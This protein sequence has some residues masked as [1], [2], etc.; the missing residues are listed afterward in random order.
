MKTKILFFTLMLL[1]ATSKAA[2]KSYSK[3]EQELSQWMSNVKKDSQASKND[4][5]K[6]LD[7]S[8]CDY[9][10]KCNFCG[11]FP[12]PKTWMSICNANGQEIL[13]GL[14]QY[15]EDRHELS[16]TGIW[17]KLT[18]DSIVHLYGSFSISNYGN[19]EMTFKTKKGGAL[20]VK[21]ISICY[22][23]GFYKDKSTKTI[24]K[25]AEPSFIAIERT[26][27]TPSHKFRYLYA[28]ISSSIFETIQYDDIPS[29]LLNADYDVFLIRND[30][31][32]EGK[33][34][35][36]KINDH[37]TVSYNF[38]EGKMI[39]NNSP[40][41]Y[42]EMQVDGDYVRYT[43]GNCSTN[44]LKKQ[45]LF[46]PKEEGKSIAE[47][48]DEIYCWE[49]YDHIHFEYKD[50]ATFTGSAKTVVTETENGKS[51]TTNL[52]S[53]TYVYANGDSFEGNLQ[54]QHLGNIFFDGET[55]FAD[56]KQICYGNY[57][58][59]YKLTNDQNLNIAAKANC[60]TTAREMAEN[61]RK[62]N[63]KEEFRK[64]YIDYYCTSWGKTLYFN[65]AKEYAKV[66]HGSYM[67]YDKK[68]DTYRWHN[69]NNCNEVSDDSNIQCIFAINPNGSRKFEIVYDDPLSPMASSN[70]VP[71]VPIYINEYTWY[72][73]GSIEKIKCFD[74]NTQNIILVCNFFTDGTLRSAYRYRIGNNGNIVLSKSKEAHPTWGGYECKQY[75]LNGNY[76]RSTSWDIGESSFG[77]FGSTWKM[78]PSPLDISNDFEEV[79][80]FD[81]K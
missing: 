37:G 73:D 66:L 76:E 18:N 50:G 46:I 68:N 62:Q 23:E 5:Y 55:T 75:D 17:N 56:D 41:K 60:P 70:Y 69:T 72:S 26:A 64:S 65:P 77:F 45:D 38:G 16:L 27:E 52:G 10:V 47:Y 20:Q 51:I 33:I 21:P 74:Y 14:A 25:V 71:N 57:L 13:C 12:S 40:Y 35:D 49:H 34:V 59:V 29:L 79:D 54:G 43:Y 63:Q 1:C 58:E 53:G 48:W 80:R 42:N 7:F 36:R 67:T 15:D 24:V 8:K 11:R 44:N 28:P 32:F 9:V 61:Y 78:A 3:V 2:I 81:C 31:T 22:F 4:K 30:F 19:H 39:L 6:E